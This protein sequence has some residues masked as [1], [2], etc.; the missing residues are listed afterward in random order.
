MLLKTRTSGGRAFVSTHSPNFY[1]KNNQSLL[2]FSHPNKEHNYRRH[3]LGKKYHLSP[4]TIN[5]GNPR[6]CSIEP[7]Q[8]RPWYIQ[9]LKC[10]H[11]KRSS[12]RK[13]SS[14]LPSH[15]S[16]SREKLVK[17]WLDQSW[18]WWRSLMIKWWRGNH[19]MCVG[20]WVGIC[21]KLYNNRHFIRF[22]ETMLWKADVS[23]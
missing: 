1:G 12:A 18:R 17:L 10:L 5:V 2:P 6:T 14:P 13:R 19:I 15:T 7:I 16:L 20:A 3:T 23:N 22:E 9:S 8:T 4:Y 11:A 21:N